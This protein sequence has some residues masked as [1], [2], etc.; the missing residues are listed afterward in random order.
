MTYL[1]QLNEIA[2]HDYKKRD[3][4]KTHSSAYTSTMQIKKIETLRAQSLFQNNSYRMYADNAVIAASPNPSKKEKV[5]AT[6]MRS[7]F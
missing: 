3:L 6:S 4:E 2:K 5:K 7:K 1:N